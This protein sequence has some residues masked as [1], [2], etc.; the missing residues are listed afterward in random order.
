MHN[1]AA[2]P[3]DGNVSSVRAH[4]EALKDRLVADGKIQSD[5]QAAAMSAGLPTFSKGT[6]TLDPNTGKPVAPP[7]AAPEFST[8]KVAPLEGTETTGT[9]QPQVPAT[10]TQPQ[11]AAPALAPQQQAAGTAAA[12][13]AAAQVTDAFA[14]YEQ[15]DLDEPD[16]PDVKVPVRVPKQYAQIMKRAFPRRADYD[17]IRQRWGEA[18]PILEPLLQDGRIKQVLP[19]LERALKD[20]VYGDFVWNGYERMQRGLPP[21][22]QAIQQATQLAQTP[23]PLPAQTQTPGGEPLV[24]PFLDEYLRNDPRFKKLETMEQRF[25]ALERERQAEAQRQQSAQQQ[26]QQQANQMM[27]AHQDLERMYPGQFSTRNGPTDAGWQKAMQFAK[28]YGYIGNYDLRAA[29][30]FGAQRWLEYETDRLAATAS[31]AAQVLE[32]VDAQ[33]AELARRQAAALAAPGAGGVTQTSMP[34]PP[35]P[36]P[37]RYQADGKTLKPAEQFLSEIRDWNALVQGQGR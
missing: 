33:A 34:T 18:A 25:E 21:I 2:L 27:L 24:D 7:Q 11:A 8:E 14:E 1:D 10:E 12:D 22:E 32:Q 5:P 4:A 19:L 16:F 17:R 31:P 36:K 3:Q 23:P 30:I 13:A 28:D 6:A 15:L 9:T 37:S 35:P 26:Q 29:I 20:P